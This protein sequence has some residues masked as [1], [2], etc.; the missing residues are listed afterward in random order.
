MQS[1]LSKLILTVLLSMAC[2]WAQG[3][4]IVSQIAD[5]QGWQSVLVVTNATASAAVASITFYKDTTGGGTTAWTPTFLEASNPAALNLPAGSSLFLHTPGTAASLTQGWAQ[6]FAGTGVTAYVIYTYS[7]PGAPKQDANAPALTAATRFLVPFDNTTGLVTTIAIVNPNPI[8]L[9][10]SAS[11]N[12][13][14][15]AVAGSPLNIPANGHLAFVM[16]TQFAGTA[17]KDGL[18]EFYSS[19]LSFSMIALRAHSPGVLSFTAVPVFSETGPPG[20]AEVEGAEVEAAGC[21]RVT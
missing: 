5:G 10:I 18:A 21:L 19:T 8:A 2:V 3:E 12:T 16:P 14:G 6:I 15:G 13:S 20:A 11:F 1:I 7:A 17:G 4:E 9:T